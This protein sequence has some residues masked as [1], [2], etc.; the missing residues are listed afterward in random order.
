MSER[1][2][3]TKPEDLGRFFMERGNVSDLDGL[4][5]LY[6]PTAVLA[7]PSGK[8]TTG[9]QAIR[10]VY[11]QLLATKP[12]FQGEVQTALRNGDLALTSTRFSGGA[13]A[14]V[15]HLQPNGTWLWIIDQPNVF[16]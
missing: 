7:F 4:V 9:R 14:E 12:K 16:K 1:P 15:A 6:E 2:R 11:A 8:V 5:E 13:T 3:A 10:R